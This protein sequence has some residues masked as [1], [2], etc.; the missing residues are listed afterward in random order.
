MKSMRAD[1]LKYTKKVYHT[2]PEYLWIKYP[3]YAVFRHA[4]NKKWYAVIMDVEPAKIGL[5][6]EDRLDILDVKCDSVLIGSLLGEEG[7]LPGFHM[8]KTSWISILLDGTVSK[9]KILKLIDLSFQMTETKSK[10]ATLR[11]RRSISVK[12]S[13]V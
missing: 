12:P 1:L 4:D 3:G 9:E 5:K 10:Q 7:F 8:N 6:G 13:D 11:I 2:E